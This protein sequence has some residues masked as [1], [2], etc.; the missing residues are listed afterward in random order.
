MF[1]S[2]CYLRGVFANIGACCSPG[3]IVTGP[4][5]ERVQQKVWGEVF[6]VLRRDEPGLRTEY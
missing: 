5:M 3:K 1:M 4:G 2:L 6:D